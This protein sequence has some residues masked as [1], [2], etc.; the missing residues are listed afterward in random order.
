MKS[1]APVYGIGVI[2]VRDLAE[3]HFRAGFTA[4][5]SGRHIIS[6]HDSSF[7]QIAGILHQQFGDRF[8]I[9]SRKMPKWLIWMVGPIATKGAMTRKMIS[10]NVGYAWKADNAKSVTELGMT[11]RDEQE[12]LVDMFQQMADNQRFD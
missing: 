12:S 3:A 4:A 8:P 9:P 2:D 1:G 6:G 7:L 5:A 10:R 11:Y